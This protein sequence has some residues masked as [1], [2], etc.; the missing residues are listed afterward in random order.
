MSDKQ[1]RA[2][3][4]P[5]D[6]ELTTPIKELVI[7][8]KDNLVSIA[9]AIREKAGLAENFAFPQGFIDTISGIESGGGRKVQGTYIPAADSETIYKLEHN[10]GVLP[11]FGLI[12]SNEVTPDD[13]NR[14]TKGIG[15]FILDFND[16]SK[17][18]VFGLST[19][20]GIAG[21][22]NLGNGGYDIT[23]ASRSGSSCYFN[24][25]TETAINVKNKLSGTYNFIF[26]AGKKYNW[27]FGRIEF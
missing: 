10:L 12:Y 3:A 22:G 26:P 17:T 24:G 15:F 1:S 27:I 18:W 20:G 21:Y 9:D 4:H 8:E 14:R 5:S 19:M 25:L 2:Y 13:G 7:T 11:N 6:E 16:L 23:D